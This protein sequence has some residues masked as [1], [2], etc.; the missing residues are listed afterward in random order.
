MQSASV[1]I[2][3]AGMAGGAAAFELAVRRGV[4]DVVL[5]DEREPVTLTSSR[6]TQGFRNWFPGP[7]DAVVRLMNRSIARLEEI[8]AETDDRFRFSPRGYF[9]ITGDDAQVDRF[10]A[11]AAVLSSYG[12]GALR[13][14][15]RGDDWIPGHAGRDGAPRD[16]AD[17]VL[18]A[19]AIRRRWPAI[20]PD[21][22]AALHVRRAGWFDAIALARWYV[23]QAAGAGVRVVRARVHGVEQAG[24]RVTGVR[25]DDGSRI[26][27]DRVVLAAGPGLPDV[28]RMLGV[29]IPLVHELHGKLTLRDVAAAIPRDL[30]MMIW[31]DPVTLDWTPAERAAIEHEG[32]HAILGRMPGGV[33][34]RPLDE[35][36][37]DLV[38][39]IWTYDMVPRA[40]IEPPTFP[41]WYG[42]AVV[43]GIM[44]AVPAMARYAGRAHE[45]LVDG[46]YYCKAIDNRPIIG[47]LGVEGAWAFGALSGYGIMSSHA[48]AE[49]LGA[50]VVGDPLPPH[51]AALLPSRFADPVYAA[52]LAG[53]DARMGQL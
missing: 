37:G 33:H 20:T 45:G 39:L 43:R 41:R 19:D 27:T 18:D 17:L 48:G 2:V 7:D 46:G 32:D 11:E 29:E 53:W 10:R 51:A 30:P 23:E 14:H 4:R 35:G 16:G 31:T 13:V 25:L 36:S 44:R 49:L 52:R 1:V 34:V 26:D 8:A 40:P 28:L 47:P 6:G 15:E 22:V 9:F 3:G 38:Y 24:G 42:E 50:H 12:A 21:V 5:V